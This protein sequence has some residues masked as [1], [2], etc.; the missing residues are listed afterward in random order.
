MKSDRLSRNKTLKV[1]KI[2]KNEAGP[3]NS[4]DDLFSVKQG[5][6]MGFGVKFDKKKEQARAV[7][8]DAELDMVSKISDESSDLAV[9]TRA[10]KLGAYILAISMKS[11]QKFRATYVARMQNLCLDAISDMF[12]A[13]TVRADSVENK[14]KREQFQTDAIIRLKML[15]YIAL[16]AENSGCILL[17]QYKQISLQLGDVIGLCAAWRKSDNDKWG[18]RQ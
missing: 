8:V 12:R 1:P 14:T 10:K 17:R 11:P 16:L 3:A 18:A 5:S 13:N 15:G 7:A 4:A 9:V 2:V 6:A